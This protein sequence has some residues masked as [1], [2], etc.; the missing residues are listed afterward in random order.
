MKKLNLRYKSTLVALFASIGMSSVMSLSMLLINFGVID[1]FALI[2]LKSWL[3]S[4]IVAF[5]SAILIVPMAQKVAS[6]M[7]SL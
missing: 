6:R 7:T 5:P 2:W 3:L 1:N 4:V